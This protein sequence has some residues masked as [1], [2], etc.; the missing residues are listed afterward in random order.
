MSHGDLAMEALIRLCMVQFRAIHFG[1]VWFST[2][3][4]NLRQPHNLSDKFKE[5]SCLAFE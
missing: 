2:S 3:C 4:V 5:K 1:V